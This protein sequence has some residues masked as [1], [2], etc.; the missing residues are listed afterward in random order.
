MPI[1]PWKAHMRPNGLRAAAE[2]VPRSSIRRKPFAIVQQQRQR[3]ERRQRRGQHHGPGARPAAAM[4]RREGL[5]QV[6][7]HGVDAEIARAHAAGDGVEVRAVAIE[8]G[9]GRMHRV[10]HLA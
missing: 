3:R 1:W 2:R 4:R 5:V 10:G 9:A 6:D 8:I 7:V